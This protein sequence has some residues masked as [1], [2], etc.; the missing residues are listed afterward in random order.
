[1]GNGYLTV[2]VTA[3]LLVGNLVLDLDAAGTCFDHLLG[4]QVGGFSVTETGI[5]V[6]NDRHNVGFI[7]V[8]L[9]LNFC[10]LGLVAFS[11]SVV[12]CGEQQVQLTG[13]SL[14]QEGVQLFDQAGN[15][16]LLVHGLVGQGAEI[17]TQGGNHPA[18]QVQVAFVGGFQVLFDGDQL[19]LTDETVPATQGLC[20]DRVVGVVVGHVLAHD[21]GGVLGNIQ[22][23]LEAVLYAHASGVFRV[24]CAPTV[25]CGFFQCGNSFDLVLVS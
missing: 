10:F 2:L 22:T 16:G 3:L 9:G 12:Q 18:G 25:T 20:V 13:V 23:G 21:G 8:D 5:D 17:G 14:A 24:D 4:H 1:M 19:L 11:A 7:T 15:G 6:G